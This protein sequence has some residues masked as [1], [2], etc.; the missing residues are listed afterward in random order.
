MS[1]TS[2]NC[3]ASRRVS[4][5]FPPCKSLSRFVGGRGQRPLFHLL[6]PAVSPWLVRCI[7]LY[8]SRTLPPPSLLSP[9]PYLCSFAHTRVLRLSHTVRLSFFSI[10]VLPRISHLPPLLTSTR[11]ACLFF[12]TFC[13]SDSVFSVNSIFHPLVPLTLPSPLVFF[14]PPP[15]YPF[16]LLLPRLKIRARTSSPWSLCRSKLSW[17]RAHAPW[18]LKRSREERECARPKRGLV[19][20]KEKQQ[21]VKGNS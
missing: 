16:L 1:K 20:L 11:A 15:N 8:P 6:V 5:N 7:R 21:G 18:I 2:L 10:F 19:E 12:S 3:P 4:F 13:F 17:L 14:L 9:F